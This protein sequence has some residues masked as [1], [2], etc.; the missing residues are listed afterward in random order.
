[1]VLYVLAKGLRLP[2]TKIR[3]K[4]SLVQ[5]PVWCRLRSSDIRVF[6]QLFRARE[7]G[8]LDDI[9]SPRLLIDCGAN[10][11]YTSAYLLSRFPTL[12]AYSIE[13]DSGNFE[14]LQANLAP[15]GRRAHPIRAGIWPVSADLK[16]SEIPFRDG[17]EW[18][19][20]VRETR[21][22]E[23]PQMKGLNIGDVLRMSG[24]ERISI[25]KID[26]EGAE[27]LIFSSHYEPWLER[28]DTLV[29]ELHGPEA[30]RIFM[31]AIAGQDFE[32]SQSGELT[33]CRRPAG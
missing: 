25:L 19:L 20:T 7:Y 11:G 6:R 12:E 4:P 21:P 5:F 2:L 10:V 18:S 27:S 30:E 16:I 14:M 28:V 9:S 22:G 8:C 32:I 33:L 3:L 17:M 26:I 24:H 13:P 29:I 31:T 1:M 15:Y 23:Q